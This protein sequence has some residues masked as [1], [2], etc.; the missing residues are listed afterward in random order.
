MR[1]ATPRQPSRI[2]DSV[3]GSAAFALLVLIGQH[4]ESLWRRHFR[5]RPCAPQRARLRHAESAGP[6]RL[7]VLRPIPATVASHGGVLF[8]LDSS[9][10][11]C[12]NDGGVSDEPGA[13]PRDGGLSRDEAAASVEF[14]IA[15]EGTGID[16]FHWIIEWSTSS[17]YIKSLNPALQSAKVSLHG[18]DPKHPGKQ[19]LRFGLE[20][21]SELVEKATS[22]GGRWT[23][24]TDTLPFYFS[25]RQVNDYAAHIVRYCAERDAFVEGAPP[26]GGSRGPRAK[27]TFRAI[28]PVPKKDR[29]THIDIY[30]SFADPYWPDEAGVRAAQAGIGPITNASG[31]SLTAVV[32]DWPATREPDPFGDVRGETPVT[33]CLR[34]IAA[35]VDE[36]SLLWLCEK[37]LPTAMVDVAATP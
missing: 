13:L 23:T 11:I 28:V 25:G 33:Q 32:R 27:S 21:K 2:R 18:P 19:H 17:F 20:S 9:T 35:A 26:A 8:P 4:H 12:A 6:F 14:L 3:D 37:L 24:D 15:E 1:S 34:G 10:G 36:T 7:G 5:N 30:L 22:A 29:V 31:M 16:G